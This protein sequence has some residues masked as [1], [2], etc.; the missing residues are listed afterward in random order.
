MQSA[1]MSDDVTL[2][3]YDAGDFDWLV[4]L[5]GRLYA[6][7]EG[8]DGTFAPLVATIL[9]DFEARHDP[10]CE[11]GWVAVRGDAP[12]GS[13]FCVKLDDRTAKLRLFLLSPEVRGIGLGKRMLDTCMGFARTCGY[14]GM[15]LWTHES[16]AAACALYRAHGWRCISSKP[17]HSFG[18]DLVE[19]AWEV[20]F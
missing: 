11:R 10:S 8:F 1:A 14:T 2:R 18:V 15:Q 17:V 5:H 19:Q 3:A 9:C 20:T 4:D 12:L 13:I 7:A 16:H 6:E